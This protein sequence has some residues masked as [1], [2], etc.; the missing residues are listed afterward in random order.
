ME[1][2]TNKVFIFSKISVF[3]KHTDYNGFV[4]PYN[5][6]EWTS[7]V[8][9]A[10]FSEICL[11]FREILNSSVKM[12][13]AKISATMHCDSVF[14][15]VIEARFTVSKIKKVSFDVIVRFFDERLQRLVCE[16]RHTLVF[17]DSQTQGFTE[18]PKGIRE[19]IVNFQDKE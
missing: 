15:D 18:V 1:V 9:E 5:Y 8:R 11:G 19:A 10:F 3:F 17:V 14:G 16:T 4:H 2:N 7:Y 6:F 12:M 13:T